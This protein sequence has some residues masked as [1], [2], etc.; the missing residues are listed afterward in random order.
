MVK[1]IYGNKAVQI[2][3]KFTQCG[4]YCSIYQKA[5]GKPWAD[6]PELVYD[7]QPHVSAPSDIQLQ[8]VCPAFPSVNNFPLSWMLLLI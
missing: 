1:W 6:F 8:R 2:I 3:R 4:F 5:I 7:I